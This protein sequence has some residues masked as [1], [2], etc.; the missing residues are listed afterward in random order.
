MNRDERSG[1]LAQ[2]VRATV[3]T[4]SQFS[5]EQNLDSFG[6]TK[7]SP[8]INKLVSSES[9]VLPLS[10]RTSASQTNHIRSTHSLMRATSSPFK[11][12]SN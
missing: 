3:D 9:S 5:W 12:A 7:N 2:F 8:A 6:E 11:L 1:M 10:M 4:S